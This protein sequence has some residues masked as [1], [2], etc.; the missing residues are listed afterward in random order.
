MTD[1]E[2]ERRAATVKVGRA[3]DAQAVSHMR[4]KRTLWVVAALALVTAVCA[5]TWWGIFHRLPSTL[6]SFPIHGQFVQHLETGAAEGAPWTR[7]PAQVALALTHFGWS[8]SFENPVSVCVEQ[9]T[10]SRAQVVI[11][12]WECKDDSITETYAAIRLERDETGAWRPT[13]YAGC[14]KGRGHLGWTTQP[15]D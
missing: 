14:W 15:A 3:A 4:T 6:A 5:M 10:P 7:H 8:D 2:G 13:D 11:H 12:E 1:R 9:V